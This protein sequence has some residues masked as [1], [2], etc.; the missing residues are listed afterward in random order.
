[1]LKYP[2]HRSLGKNY[3]KSWIRHPYLH[4][5]LK[6]IDISRFRAREQKFTFERMDYAN[7]LKSLELTIDSILYSCQTNYTT[8]SWE[9][10]KTGN[11]ASKSTDWY[12]Q[13][14]LAARLKNGLVYAVHGDTV[15]ILEPNNYILNNIADCHST[16]INAKNG[17]FLFTE[18]LLL[19]CGMYSQLK[20]NDMWLTSLRQVIRWI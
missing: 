8:I 3:G 4:A 18:N 10:F 7:R 19:G 9:N 5:E 15:S 11:R 2:R 12:L 16:L 6:R 14:N 1:M 20:S 17:Y 13:S